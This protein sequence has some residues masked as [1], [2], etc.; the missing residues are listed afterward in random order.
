VWTNSTAAAG[1]GGKAR[2][3]GARRLSPTSRTRH[4]RRRFCPARKARSRRSPRRAGPG[5]PAPTRRRKLSIP[6]SAPLEPRRAPARTRP[7]QPA[8]LTEP[9]AS[10]SPG[11]RGEPRGLAPRLARRAPARAACSRSAS[12]ALAQELDALLVALERGFQAQP[13]ALRARRRSPPGAPGARRSLARLLLRRRLPWVSF[14]ESPRR[15]VGSA[16]SGRERC[17]RA[18]PPASAEKDRQQGPGKSRA[19]SAPRRGPGGPSA[20]LPDFPF[21]VELLVSRLRPVL[22]SPRA[23][24]RPGRYPFREG[25]VEG[26]R[27]AAPRR[28]RSFL[29]NHPP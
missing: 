10:G 11:V 2:S 9:L 15:S 8:A 25:T 1:R 6:R 28:V 18:A 16:R 24:A 29:E 3:V 4:G 5:A 26:G 20:S 12:V 17:G 22:P 27:T 19:R 13:A 23:A 7:R 14:W 21:T